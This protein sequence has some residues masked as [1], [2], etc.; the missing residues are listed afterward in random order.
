MSPIEEKLCQERKRLGQDLINPDLSVVMK[1]CYE[2][3]LK[4]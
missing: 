1:K 4:N 2:K 3:Q